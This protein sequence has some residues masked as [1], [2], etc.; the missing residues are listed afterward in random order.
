MATVVE[1]VY[2][3]LGINFR[4]DVELVENPSPGRIASSS[5]FLHIALQSW[6]LF[7]FL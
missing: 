4:K 3:F 5:S 7:R 1:Y 6:F 2:V